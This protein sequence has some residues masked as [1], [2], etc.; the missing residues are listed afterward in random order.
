MRLFQSGGL[1]SGGSALSSLIAFLL[2]IS[3]VASAAHV[4]N[5]HAK[6]HHR[7]ES[8]GEKL[9]TVA[10]QATQHVQSGFKTVGYYVSW[11]I[12]GRNWPVTNLQSSELTHVLY[13]FAG[14]DNKT[15]DASLTDTFADVEKKYPGDV[16][17]PNN[18]TTN[19]YG[20][21]KQLYLQ[22]KAN[23]NMKTLLSFGGW[24]LRTYFAPALKNLSGRQNFARTSVQLLKDLGFDGLDIDWEYPNSTSEAAALVDTCRL[25]REELDNY[26]RN[27]TGHP[28]F[29]LTLAVPAGPDHF[30]YFDMP[31]LLPYVDFINLMGY[32]YAGS[33]SN[34][35]GHMSNLYKSQRNPRSTEFDTQTAVDYYLG[36]GWPKEKLNLGMPLY[37]RAFANT[38]GPGTNFTAST[39]GS[40]EPGVWDYKVLPQALNGSQTFYDDQVVASWAYNNRTRYMVS[41]DEPVI[42]AKKAEYI[43]HNGLGGAMWWET[44]GDAPVNSSR[45]LIRTVVDAFEGCGVGV[46]Y[47]QN[48]L[49][50]PGSR[51][52]NLRAGMEGE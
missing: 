16:D 50:Y 41:Y 37:G 15:G 18:K 14:I 11:A 5:G 48:W 30:Q 13:A 42:A 36:S 26:A 20:N 17:P 32:D 3:T 21:L 29:L 10:R 43:E 12:Y 51:Y 28:H 1:L 19:L 34:Y 38:L 24:N 27:L 40:W 45:S 47:C 6:F 39:V 22:K 44:S 52:A 33:F 46:E 8:R 23:R 25:F 7:V 4:P 2:C 31:G 49:E 9:D 35:S